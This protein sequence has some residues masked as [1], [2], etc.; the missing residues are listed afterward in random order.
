MLIAVAVIASLAL[1]GWLI[2][3]A[4]KQK[5][6]TAHSISYAVASLT[7]VFTFAFFMDMDIPKLVKIVVSIILGATLLVIAAYIQRRKASKA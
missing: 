5:P 3:R 6:I 2:Y 7:G 4:V 1:I